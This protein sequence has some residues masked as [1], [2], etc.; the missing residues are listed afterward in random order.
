MCYLISLL[1]HTFTTYQLNIIYTSSHPHDETGLCTL[2]LALAPSVH[3][4]AMFDGGGGVLCYAGVPHT[5]TLRW[6]T[7]AIQSLEGSDESSQN[8]KEFCTDVQ[9]ILLNRVAS[10]ARYL[11]GGVLE[12]NIAHRRSVAVLYMLYNIRCDPMHPHCR[13]LPVSYVPVRVTRR[14]LVATSVYLCAS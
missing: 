8:S 10:G 2:V 9:S 5:Y 6:G 11:T 1:H 12:C 14:A 3:V 7:R 13:A 4:Q